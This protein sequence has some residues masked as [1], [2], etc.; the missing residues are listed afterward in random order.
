[1][2]VP[3]MIQFIVAMI[4][5]MNPLGS[6]SIFLD[7]TRKS[8]VHEQRKTALE[9]TLAILIIMLVTLWSGRAL[10][11]LLGITIP[12][13]RF[14]GGIILLLMG[15]SMLQSRESAVSHT[16]ED[17]EAAKERVSI[18]IVPLALPVIVGPGAIST[19][20]IIAGD[21][22]QLMNKMIMSVICVLLAIGMGI[23]LYFAVPIAK[24]VG[25]SVIKVVTRIMGM[26]IMAI[27]V[28]MLAD[29]L[30]GLFPMMQ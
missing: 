17:D 30:I 2:T 6:L 22:P 26:I 23:M 29:G 16:S 13:F 27:A 24:T 4:I 25:T 21:Y 15:L 1:M 20:I 8:L 3:E 11:A 7:L 5:M 12:A 10:L 14:A 19:L 18:S 28:G 9:A